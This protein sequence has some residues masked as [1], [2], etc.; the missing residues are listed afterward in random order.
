MTFYN[1]KG[2]LYARINGKRVSTKLKDTKANRKLFESYSKNDEFFKKFNV[3]KDMLTVIELCEEVLKEKEKEL[4]PTSYRSYESLYN[5]RI[6][7]YFNKMIPSEVTPLIIKEWYKTF[8]DRQ[9]LKTCEAVLKPAFENAI[10]SKMI[11]TT[12]FV[13]KKPKFKSDYEINPFSLEELKMILKYENN[14]IKNF[15][16]ISFFTGLRTGELCGLKW[17][18]IDFK[19]N[20]LSVNRTITAGFEQDPKTKSSKAKIDLP[21]EALPYFKS[22]QLKTG[23]REYVFYSKRN[24]NPY[25]SSTTL[26]SKLKEILRKLNIKERTI[27]QTRHTFA[28]IKL[29]MGER[30]EWVSYMLRHKSPRITQEIYFKYMPELDT[31][32]VII[33]LDMAQNRHSS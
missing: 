17:S 22:Q 19:K 3:K 13:I 30:L 6:V 31:E 5:S 16:G 10:L 4:K 12:P 1:R 15:L 14:P 7:P 32:R 18:D 2:M 9:T 11:T 8:T 21:I 24:I 20:K 33:N 26:A 27:Y 29:S 25:K 23:L 28:S